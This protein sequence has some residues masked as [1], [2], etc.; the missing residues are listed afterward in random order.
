MH[1]E[2]LLVAATATLRKSA[3]VSPTPVTREQVSAI[4]LQESRTPEANPGCLYDESSHMQAA[5][6]GDES[7]SLTDDTP[8]LLREAIE[9]LDSNEYI[10]SDT[11]KGTLFRG[12]EIMEGSSLVPF[13]TSRKN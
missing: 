11:D 5:D 3:D 13:G 6:I 4:Y 12:L 7:L 2:P 10:S 8:T 1:N 9:P